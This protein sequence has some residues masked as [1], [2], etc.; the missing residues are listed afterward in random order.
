MSGDSWSVSCPAA[1][2]IPRSSPISPSSA[3]DKTFRG[4]QQQRTDTDWDGTKSKT[5]AWIEDYSLLCLKLKLNTE[6]V[7]K[8]KIRLSIRLSIGTTCSLARNSA[9]GSTSEAAGISKFSSKS[10]MIYLS[11]ARMFD[12]CRKDKS[13]DISEWV[14]L[15]LNY[16]DLWPAPGQAA[17]GQNKTSPCTASLFL[18]LSLLHSL[19]NL[20]AGQTCRHYSHSHSNAFSLSHVILDIT[21]PVQYSTVQY[22]TVQYRGLS[23]A[24]H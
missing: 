10:L 21:I 19:W 15:P 9:A 8:S 4:W 3:W 14:K 22:S 2:A 6:Q 20:T 1:G 13:T 7:D 5:K 12:Y 24:F 23:T 11:S 17:I 16:L 18:P